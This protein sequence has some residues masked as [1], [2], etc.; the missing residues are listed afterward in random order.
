M[1]LLSLLGFVAQLCIIASLGSIII[2]IVS[3]ST[4]ESAAVINEAP[5]TIE[6]IDAS[7][8]YATVTCND[9][10]IVADD[11]HSVEPMTT[12]NYYNAMTIKELKALCKEHH[13]KQ[14]SALRKHDLVLLL[15]EYF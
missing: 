9:S 6:A 1:S 14:Y 7:L 3:S 11:H 15:S 12:Y 4:V 8:P 5:V 13:F 10:M 2:S